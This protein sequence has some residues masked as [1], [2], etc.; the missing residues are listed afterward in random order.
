MLRCSTKKGVFGFPR[1]KL[2][3]FPGFSSQAFYFFAELPELLPFVC[4]SCVLLWVL[5]AGLWLASWFYCLSNLN[6]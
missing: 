2:P 6:K 3:G 1:E 5:L 4:S